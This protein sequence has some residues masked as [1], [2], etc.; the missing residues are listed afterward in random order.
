MFLPYEASSKIFFG[1]YST[2]QIT[3]VCTRE[4]LPIAG[5][6]KLASDSGVKE[7]LIATGD[8]MNPNQ[9]TSLRS[10]N[11]TAL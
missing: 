7:L 5:N 4:M 10:H 2:I 3:V 1:H 6:W 8:L 9:N 11:N